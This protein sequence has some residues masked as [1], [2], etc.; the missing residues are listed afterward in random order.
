MV[1]VKGVDAG[2]NLQAGTFEAALNGTMLARVQ[3]QV[4]EP[5]Q[6]SRDAEVFGRGFS[7]GGLQISSHHL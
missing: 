4:G 6:G 2:L 5:F 1:E 7:D 3:F